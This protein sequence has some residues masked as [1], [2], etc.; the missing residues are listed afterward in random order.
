MIARRLRLSFLNSQAAL[1]ALPNV[2]EIMGDE[3][4]WNDAEKKVNYC[5]NFQNEN[6]F[7]LKFFSC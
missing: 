7:K 4:K 1:E 2:I 5:N 3:L 6:T